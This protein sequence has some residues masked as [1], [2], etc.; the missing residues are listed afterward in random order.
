MN[1]VFKIG[2]EAVV[3]DPS[4]EALQFLKSADPSFRIQSVRPTGGFVP[5]WQSAKDSGL[6]EERSHEALAMLYAC[7]LCARQCKANRFREKGKCG[8]MDKTFYHVPFIHIAEE[9]VINPALVINFTGCSMNCVHCVRHVQT[10]KEILSENAEP[11]WRE[12]MTCSDLIRTSAL[13][14]L[15]AEI[16]IHT[17]PG[18]SRA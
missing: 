15:R 8:L 7:E 11:F 5:K 4:Y 2:N 3:M 18:F 9:P 13:W 10:A 12:S 6:L 14:N 16:P 17:F 1:E